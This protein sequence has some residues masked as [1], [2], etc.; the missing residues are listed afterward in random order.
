MEHERA[1]MTRELETM[2]AK[3]GEATSKVNVLQCQVEH[4]EAALSAK[5]QELVKT[6]EVVKVKTE[7]NSQLLRRLEGMAL[8]MEDVKSAYSLEVAKGETMATKI[9]EANRRIQE[10]VTVFVN[11]FYLFDFSCRYCASLT[12]L[13]VDM[14]TLKRVCVT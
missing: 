14:E 8:E 7:E 4:A 11:F 6:G 2:K 3:M 13:T 9:S 5:A 12:S 10:L 1:H